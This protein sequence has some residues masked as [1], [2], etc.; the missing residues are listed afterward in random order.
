MNPNGQ[1]LL[2]I[3]FDSNEEICITPNKFG[4]MS[5]PLS[6]IYSNS[7]IL[8]PQTEKQRPV[9]CRPE[10]I[11]LVS[12][13]PIK[14]AR[15]DENVT[16]YRSFM[17]ELDSG[18]LSEQ[19][20]YVKNKNMPYSVCVFSGGKS[21][22]F[23][24]TLTKPLPSYEVWHFYAEWIL[25]VMDKADQQTKNPSRGIRMAGNFRDGNEMKLIDVNERIELETLTN[26]LSKH[27]ELAPKP[28]E[29]RQIVDTDVDLLALPSWVQAEL[30]LGIDTSKGRN[31]RW[32]A[33]AYECGLLGWNE[34]DTISILGMYF[35]EER[36]FTKRE[37][38]TAIKSGIRKVKVQYG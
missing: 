18:N 25:S 15:R 13:N 20:Q 37:W 9:M 38:E 3:L 14:G 31:N 21:L 34:D 33:I 26:W 7:F 27:P 22:H 2:D 8:S 11:M 10:D 28:Q 30:E 36:D 12:I 5:I 4:Y 24:I 1:R 32:F 23:G 16:A 17:V 35:E 6:E 19:F 29:K